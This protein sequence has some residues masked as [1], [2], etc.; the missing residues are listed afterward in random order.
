M[1]A[2]GEPLPDLTRPTRAEIAA[3]LKQYPAAVEASENIRNSTNVTNIVRTSSGFHIT[4]YNINC[5]ALV[6][7]SGIFNI[8][9]PPPRFLSPL[10]HLSRSARDGAILVI[11]SGFT[12]ADI[13]ISAPPDRRIIHLFN[14]DPVNHP[15]PLKACHG[16]AYPEYAWIYRQMKQAAEKAPFAKSPKKSVSKTPRKGPNSATRS[17]SLRDWSTTYDGFANARILSIAGDSMSDLS[18]SEDE[19][20]PSPLQHAHSTTQSYPD[21]AIIEIGRSSFGHRI[22]RTISSFHYAVGRRSTLSYLSPSLRDEVLAPAYNLPSSRNFDELQTPDHCM[23]RNRDFASAMG[24]SS[25]SPEL[26]SGSSLRG[27]I[28][29]LATSTD[30][31]AA[32]L[33]VAPSVFAIGS[34][35]GDSLVRFAYGG[36]CAVAG[37]IQDRVTTQASGD[38]AS[39]GT[40]DGRLM[41]DWQRLE[42]NWWI[43]S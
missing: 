32:G 7:A 24:P 34:L 5:R 37:A 15:S 16:S 4:P 31:S 43:W 6:L 12:A 1:R 38:E 13:I 17:F 10:T 39:S 8:R 41:S 27:K 18:N 36:C 40:V 23:P 25:R 26:I 28:E 21:S 22:T 19:A 2:K 33:E 11:G 14:W 35:T 9:L 20:F 29:D 42:E 30:A 3:Y